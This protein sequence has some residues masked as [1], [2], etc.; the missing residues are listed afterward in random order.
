[1]ARPGKRA[2]KKQ[3]APSSTAATSNP[4]VTLTRASAIVPRNTEWAWKGRI[5]L[6]AVTLTVGPGGLGKSTLIYDRIAKLTQGALEGDVFGTPVTVLIATA[7][8]DPNAVVVPRLMAVGADLDRVY[9]VT[10]TH[11][12]VVGDIELPRDI[13]QLGQRVAQKHA[14]FLFVDPLMA[15]ISLRLDAHRDQHVRAVLGPLRRLGE[16]HGIAIVCTLHLNKRETADV[17]TRVGG[18]VGFGAAA[19]SVLLLAKGKDAPVEDGTDEVEETEDTADDGSRIMAH[20]KCNVGPLTP[21]LQLRV[22]EKILTKAGPKGE[23]I[24]TSTIVWGGEVSISAEKLLAEAGGAKAKPA[25]RAMVLLRDLL[26]SGP[27]PADDVKAVLD[28][29]K[30]TERARKT[31]KAKLAIQ[32]AKRGFA[33]G[34]TWALPPKKATVLVTG[35][36]P[37]SEKEERERVNNP[38]ILSKKDKGDGASRGNGLLREDVADTE[39]EGGRRGTKR[40]ASLSPLPRPSSPGKGNTHTHLHLA[41]ATRENAGALYTCE[42]RTEKSPDWTGEMAVGR[43][44]HR[45]SAW[46]QQ[47]KFGDDYFAVSAS[48]KQGGGRL[49]RVQGLRRADVYRG[50]LTIAGVQYRV[51]GRHWT[52]RYGRTVVSLVALPKEP[53]R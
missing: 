28:A 30:I 44:A 41:R 12:E 52:D 21:S 14:K 35:K 23:D 4:V 45:L 37:S 9:I 29:E 13:E 39:G 20:A 48:H 40:D 2:K 15:H 11:E 46:T 22:N 36:C 7:E 32:S 8:D 34:W 1:M 26:F 24:I 49:F 33:A 42:K 43:F 18:S 27:L 47:T 31:A 5:P 17:L 38:H 19:R 51:W 10:L 53:I 3:S 16:E 50:D 25:N 6:G